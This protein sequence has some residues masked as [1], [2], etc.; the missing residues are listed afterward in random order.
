MIKS[1]N[2]GSWYQINRKIFT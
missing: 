1:R 2:I